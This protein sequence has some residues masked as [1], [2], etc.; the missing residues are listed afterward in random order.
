MIDCAPLEVISWVSLMTFMLI[1]QMQL[2]ICAHA[3]VNC[4]SL[5]INN[6]YYFN[7]DELLKLRVQLTTKEIKGVANNRNS[8]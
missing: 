3:D 8:M 4:P 6:I 1:I 2:H 5:K 7:N